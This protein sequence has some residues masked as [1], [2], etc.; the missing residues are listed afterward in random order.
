[1]KLDI[2]YFVHFTV[3]IRSYFTSFLGK[4]KSEL[5]FAPYELNTPSG[6]SKLVELEECLL[7]GTW[8]EI[9]TL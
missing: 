2:G 9:V 1:M 7:Y 8:N 4:A 5:T 6:L 3:P